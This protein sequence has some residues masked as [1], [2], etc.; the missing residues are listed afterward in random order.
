MP[1]ALAGL[2]VFTTSAAVLVLEILAGRILAPYVGATLQTY[3]AVIG[4]VLAG[5]A[6]GTWLGGRLADRLDPRRLLSPILLL[7]GALTFATLPVIAVFG[8]ALAGRDPVAIVLLATVGFF[9]PAAVLSAVTPT[10]IKLVLSDLDETGRVVGQLSALGT[11]G[12]I[13]GTFATGFVLLAAFP[14]RPIV[15]AI[16]ASLLAGGFA[17]GLWLPGGRPGPFTVGL[18]A[19]AAAGALLAPVPCELESAYFCARVLPDPDRA[20]GRTLLL[21][22]L[23]HSYVDLADPSHLEFAYTVALAAVL[24]AHAGEAGHVVH[25]GGGGFTLPRATAAQRPA[26]RH[27]VVE[28]DPAIVTLAEEQLGLDLATDGLEVVLDDARRAVAEDDLEH[29]EVVIGDVFASLAVPWHLTTVEF[30]EDVA[31][32]LTPAGVYAVNLIDHPPARFARAQA[33]TL[34]AVFDDV[35]VLAPDRWWAQEAGGNVVLVAGADIDRAG[36]EAALR[37]RGLDW[38]LRDGDELA[39]FLAEGVVLTDD[40]APVEQLLGVGDRGRRHTPRRRTPRRLTP[41]R[42][43]PRRLTPRRLTPRGS[44]S[45]WG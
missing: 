22:D 45:E 15:L 8:P 36:V 17:L 5:I 18:L 26:T 40:Y 2:L 9:A 23:R 14:T 37:A 11:A 25:L 13:V 1:S 28:I 12:A 16:G 41:R 43:T 44:G 32:R 10:V 27:T 42:H 30:L 38:R 39:A 21:D 4:T 19:L 7:G 34:T 29:A 20:E 3:T 31:A 35:V 6:L 24:D 33:A